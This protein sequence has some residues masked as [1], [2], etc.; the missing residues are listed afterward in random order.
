MVVYLV[1]FFVL[2]LIALLLKFFKENFETIKIIYDHLAKMIF[3]NMI[4]RL[5]IES[6]LDI[7]LDAASNIQNV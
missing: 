4:I 1:G 2:V 5:L 3:W 7:S 6:Y